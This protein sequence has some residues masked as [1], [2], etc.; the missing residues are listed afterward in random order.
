[1]AANFKVLGYGHTGMTVRSSK[2]YPD[3]VSPQCPFVD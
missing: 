2:I 1:M 3:V